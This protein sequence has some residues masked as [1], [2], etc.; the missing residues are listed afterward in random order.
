MSV[1]PEWLWPSEGTRAVA[2]CK[3]PKKVE[4]PG[5]PCRASLSRRSMKSSRKKCGGALTRPARYIAF[6]LAAFFFVPFFLAVFFLAA[7]LATFFFAAFFLA[8]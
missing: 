6:F 2:R 8:T 4:T 3:T 5:Q 7:F 1:R